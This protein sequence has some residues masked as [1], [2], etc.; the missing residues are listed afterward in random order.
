[1][2][3][4]G[5]AAPGGRPFLLRPPRSKLLGSLLPAPW[6]APAPRAT[7]AA[8]PPAATT[9]AGRC[10]C[11]SGRA[12]SD[13]AWLLLREQRRWLVVAVDRGSGYGDDVP[14]VLPV[15]V[16]QMCCPGLW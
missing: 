2:A 4:A 5:F 8:A 3:F 6:V 15:T 10:C 7:P 12:S 9:T 16:T 14:L 11:R 1:M 13:D